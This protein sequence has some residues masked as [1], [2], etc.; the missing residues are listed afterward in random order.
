[1]CCRPASKP[2]N[3]ENSASSTHKQSSLNSFKHLDRHLTKHVSRLAEHD[4]N[5]IV[6]FTV[7]SHDVRQ[8]DIIDKLNRRPFIWRRSL[9]QNSAF[10][11]S[12]TYGCFLA[13]NDKT[14]SSERC[15]LPNNYQYKCVCFAMYNS[16][17]Y[18]VSRHE[19]E[20]IL[21]AIII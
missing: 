9:Q 1:M 10:A 3:A 7:S 14:D 4:V 6:N 21:T 17:L 11:A 5:E 13:D 16:V 12:I 15:T 19:H 18:T 2:D 20:D 8:L